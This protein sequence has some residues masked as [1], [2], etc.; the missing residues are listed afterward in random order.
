MEVQAALN[1]AEQEADRV[2]KTALVDFVAANGSQFSMLVGSAETTLSWRYA[3][4]DEP[5][6]MS[7]GDAD[8]TGAVA[9]SR[10]FADRIDVP[11]WAMIPRSDGHAALNEFVASN[12][13]PACVQWAEYVPPG[14]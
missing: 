13:I 6:Y 7:L 11:R 2:G 12:D 5:R 3:G 8:A 1:A 9:V 10:D 14:G 4:D